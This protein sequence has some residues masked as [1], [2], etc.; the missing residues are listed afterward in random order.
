M[1]YILRFFIAT[2]F[3]AFSSISLFGQSVSVSFN[4]N[5]MYQ[6]VLENFDPDQNFVDVAGTFNGWD[7]SDHVLEDEEGDMIY[8]ITI[9]GFT[10]GETIEFKFRIDGAWDGR[11]EFPGEGPDGNRSYTV[12]AEDNVIDVWYSDELPPDGPPIA[13]FNFSSSTVFENGTVWF[14]DRSGGFV[15]EWEWE[16]EGGTPSASTERNPVV[17][18]SQTGTFDVTLIAKHEEEA[19]TLT[20][21]DAIT[22]SEW[23]PGETHWWNDAVFYEIFVRSFFD[24]DGDGI[25]DFVG[26][27]EKL[28]YLNDGD[29]D[30]GESLGI[31]G[32]WLM[33]I[34]ESPS[35]HGYDVLDYESVNSE[36]GTMDEFKDFLDAA[37][38][39]GI[40]V[41]I[42]YV[43][44]HSSSQHQWF[45]NS[46]QNVEDY[47]DYYYWSD[48]HPGYNGPWGQ[49]VWHSSGGE[50]YYGL[51]WGGMPDLN[52]NHEPVKQKIFDAAD[53]WLTE[54]GVDGFRLDAVMFIHKDGSQLEHVPE[55]FEFWNEFNTQ[56]KSSNPDAVTVGEAWTSTQQVIPYVSDDRIDIA[57]EFDLAYAIMGAVQGGNANGLVDQ[58]QLVYDSYDFLQ[59]ATFLTNHDKNRVMSEF[60]DDWNRARTAASIYLTLPG[61]PFIYYGEEIGMTGTK[62]DPDIRTPMQWDSST[63]SGFTTGSPWRSVNSNY[64]NRNVELMD[65]DPNSLLNWYRNLISVRNNHVSL[66]RGQYQNIPNSLEPLYTFAREYEDEKVLVMI[67]TGSQQLELDELFVPGLG[68]DEG[69]YD[70]LN[71][72]TG[73]EIVISVSAS[74][75]ITGYDFSPYETIIVSPSDATPVSIEGRG[76]VVDEFSLDQN[77]PNPFNPVT[78]INY[79]L[80][81]S[82]EVSFSVY[83]LLGQKVWNSSKGTV[84]AGSHQVQFDAGSLSSGVYIYQLNVNGQIIDT[85]KMMLVK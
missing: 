33:P 55:T 22:V 31:T 63:H 47:R 32:I 61:V 85:K 54:I 25:G 16:F 51:F 13:D 4:V 73:E 41:I 56:V 8:S 18:Y 59:Y 50:Y 1:K 29:P 49:N 23:E 79:H 58:M 27:T 64:T 42:D 72:A 57:F 34:H 48:T 2:L 21:E 69:Q 40:K 35:Y 43:V 67:N 6:E 10:P 7:G 77:Y 30:S 24:S 20:I 68:I 37:H 83:N 46:Q 9:D 19:D 52:F 39:R 76:E 66:R 80:P 82:A 70:I 5:M 74:G 11:E 15:T 28:D 44:N 45:V 12:Q 14:T 60:N 3:L 53:F 75:H 38:E 65:E 26:M 71:L 17:T 84:P 36:Y 78:T 62:P 81:E